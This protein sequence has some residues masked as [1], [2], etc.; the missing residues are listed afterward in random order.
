MNNNQTDDHILPTPAANPATSSNGAAQSAPAMTQA[1]QQYTGSQ[2]DT[3][4]RADD[5]DL[6]EKAWVTKAK[7]I[8]DATVGDPKRQSNELNKMKS[9]YISKR[10][11][12]ELPGND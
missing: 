1:G 12:K 6:I 11:N 5:I 10:F 9:D 3:P 4:I 2:T 8:V 7:S